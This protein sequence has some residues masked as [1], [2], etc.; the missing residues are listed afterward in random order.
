MSAHFTVLA[1]GSSGNSSFLQVGEFGLLIDCGLAPRILGGRL[2]SIGASWE[3]VHAVILTHTHGDHWNGYTL[4][5]LRSKRIPLY[6]H[7]AQLNHLNAAAESFASLHS[8]SLTRSYADAP[9]ALSPDLK[10]QPIAVS[11]DAD[12]TF[13]FRFD[14]ATACGS[15]MGS[16]IR[17][18]SWAAVR[19]ICWM[20]SAGWERLLSNT[21]TTN[22]WSERVLGRS[23]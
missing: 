3:R 19:R 2:A 23:S 18:R 13:A 14:G 9:F 11:H 22:R 17:D 7:S 15:G 5:H 20:H 16:R 12:P 21:I 8:A 4:A 1:S 10:C 6:A